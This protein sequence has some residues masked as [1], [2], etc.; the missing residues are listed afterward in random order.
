V[1]EHQTAGQPIHDPDRLIKWFVSVV[2]VGV[3]VNLLSGLVAV[4]K[5]AWL[6]PAVFVAVLLVVAPR[7]GLLRQER[8][9]ATRWARSL[10]SLALLGYLAV[11]VW[12]SITGWPLLVMILSVAFLWGAGVL[13]MWSTLRSRRD[14]EGVAFG[15]ACLLGGSSALLAGVASLLDISTLVGVPL[16]LIGVALLVAAV[17]ELLGKSLYGVVIVL[18]GL[19]IL[20][21]AISHLLSKFDLLGIAF[22]LVGVATLL[23]GL[24]HFVKRSALTWVTFVLAGVTGTLLSV[25][26]LL[27]GQK[28]SGVAL[29]LCAAFYVLGS[30]GIL[31]DKLALF[32]VALALPGAAGVLLGAG[33]LLDGETVLGVTILLAGVALLLG[34]V[35]SLYRPELA[36]RLAAWLT[37]RDDATSTE[38]D[39][40]GQ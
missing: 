10:A 20:L 39:E 40:N 32:Q 34:G 23:R 5:W 31:L 35:A 24:A 28:L 30:V 26:L 6:P 21:V 22:L 2:L 14:L 7:T 9:G 18:L 25:A 3:G 4:Q 11:A 1:D 29:L 38:I 37:K 33:L 27:N 15:T 36:R 19:A 12:G 17:S 13:L 16:L 8:H